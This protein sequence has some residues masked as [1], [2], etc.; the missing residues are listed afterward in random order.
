MLDYHE[1]AFVSPVV[2]GVSRHWIQ[3]EEYESGQGNDHEQATS[4]LF[5]SILQHYMREN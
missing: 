5:H 2:C 3:D 1:L 4:S